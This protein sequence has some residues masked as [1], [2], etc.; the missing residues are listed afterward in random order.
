MRKRGKRERKGGKER[1]RGKVR[2][3]KERV[4]APREYDEVRKSTLQKRR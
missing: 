1:E 3:R 4:N 2:R